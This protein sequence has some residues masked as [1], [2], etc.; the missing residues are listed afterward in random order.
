[1][2]CPKVGLADL[3]GVFA[4]F[5]AVHADGTGLKNLDEVVP[6]GRIGLKQFQHGLSG[7]PEWLHSGLRRGVGSAGHAS[8]DCNWGIASAEETLA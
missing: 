1:M 6:V 3:I 8:W 5:V 7:R 2:E 4:S